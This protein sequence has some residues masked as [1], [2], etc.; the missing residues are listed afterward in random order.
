MSANPP[1]LPLELVHKVHEEV[2]AKCDLAKWARVAKAFLEPSRRQLYFSIDIEVYPY[3]PVDNVYHYTPK[4]LSLLT[5]LVSFP[6]LRQFVRDVEFDNETSSLD[7]DVPGVRTALDDAVFSPMLLLPALDGVTVPSM[8]TEEWVTALLK[9]EQALQDRRLPPPLYDTLDLRQPSVS[10]WTLLSRHPEVKHLKF[11][12]GDEWFSLI[13]LSD[14]PK[15]PLNLR[16]SS[17][18]F[19][20]LVDSL[21]FTTRLTNSSA[22]TLSYLDI[23]LELAEFPSLAFFPALRHLILGGG[24][25]SNERE[26]SRLLAALPE[27]INLR[28]LEC[29]FS[30]APEGI[31]KLCSS[32]SKGLATRVPASLQRLSLITLAVYTRVPFPPD[33]LVDFLRAPS[34]A[35]LQ[36]LGIVMP[37]RDSAAIDPEWPASAEYDELRQV[38]AER[39]IQCVDQPNW[40]RPRWR[41]A[42]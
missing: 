13:D 39:G 22:A 9:V 42:P 41:T 30:L 10:G 20:Q 25:Y 24:G 28:T 27:L 1:R 21:D 23:P 2:N 7:E 19:T 3:A 40:R 38:C 35:S 4:T 8:G 11:S 12:S 31:A 34:S 15:T 18:Y 33:A 17:L 37:R 32:A 14:F 29:S 26:V 6:G 36:A 16:L 5:S